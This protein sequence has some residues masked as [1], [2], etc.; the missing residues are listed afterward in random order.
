MFYFGNTGFKCYHFWIGS[1]LLLVNKHVEI[2]SFNQV[3]KFIIYSMNVISPI[4]LSWSLNCFALIVWLMSILLK[5]SYAITILYYQK[6][7]LMFFS[8]KN[9]VTL[10]KISYVHSLV[11]YNLMLGSF[12]W[13]CS[14]NVIIIFQINS[15]D[16]GFVLWFIGGTAICCGIV[17]LYTWVYS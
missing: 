11:R 3:N 2:Y 6:S 8:T 10:V 5:S 12:V 4:Y 14:E 9:N 7:S 15:I 13:I 17:N 16:K 1:F